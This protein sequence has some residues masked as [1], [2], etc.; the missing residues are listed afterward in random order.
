MLL[1]L[2]KHFGALRGVVPAFRCLAVYADEAAPSG[3]HC[4]ACQEEG[5]PAAAEVLSTVSAD[6]AM[7]VPGDPTSSFAIA[8]GVPLNG[9]LEFATDHPEFINDLLQ[10]FDPLNFEFYEITL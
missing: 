10:T 5:K 2:L 4:A 8:V 7:D 6:P 1:L 3:C 9:V